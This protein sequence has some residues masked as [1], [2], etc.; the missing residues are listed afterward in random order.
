MFNAP[1]VV[2]RFALGAVFGLKLGYVTNERLPI[3]S[4]HGCYALHW[5]LTKTV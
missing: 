3:L 5:V 2:P 1:E 4:E